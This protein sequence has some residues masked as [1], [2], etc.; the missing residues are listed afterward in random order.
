MLVPAR[1]LTTSEQIV[2]ETHF[3][4]LT[5]NQQDSCH[6]QGPLSPAYQTTVHNYFNNLKFILQGSNKKYLTI[7]MIL[8]FIFFTNEH[9][10]M[11]KRALKIKQ[12]YNDDNDGKQPKTFGLNFLIF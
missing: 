10:N 9:A 2:D 12:K 6:V 11:I 1:S 7:M 4:L 8:Y 3:Q 5:M